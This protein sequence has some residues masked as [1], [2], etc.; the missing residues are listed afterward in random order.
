MDAGKQILIE[1]GKRGLRGYFFNSAQYHEL[2]KISDF[3]KAKAKISEFGYPY[4]TDAENPKEVIDLLKRTEDRKARNGCSAWI[5]CEM[6]FWAVISLMT[7][8]T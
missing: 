1:L 7:C 4:V 2:K 8:A 5:V 6:I 3:D